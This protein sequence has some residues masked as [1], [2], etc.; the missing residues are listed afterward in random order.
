MET[1]FRV[2][3]IPG[4]NQIRT[5]LD[6]IDLLVMGGKLRIAEAAINALVFVSVS[7]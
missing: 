1:L 4:D 2:G 5:L 6:G 3:Q 7:C